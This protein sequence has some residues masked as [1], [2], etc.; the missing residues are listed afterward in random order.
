MAKYLFGEEESG[1]I[2]SVYDLL[3]KPQVQWGVIYCIGCGVRLIPKVKGEEMQ[4]HFAHKV[5]QECSQ[6][7]Y[8]H[9]LGKRLFLEQYRE[10]LAHNTPF[11]IDISYANRCRK[12]DHLNIMPAKDCQLG[13]TVKRFDLTTYYQEIILEQRDGDFIPDLLLR[14]QKNPQEKI[15]IEIAVTSFLSEKKAHSG[16]RVIEIRL[17]SDADI[18]S[19]SARHITADDALLIGFDQAES[20]IVD[21]ECHC[22]FKT[23]FVFYLFPT[24][25]AILKEKS[26]AAIAYDLRSKAIIHHKVLLPFDRNDADLEM[27]LLDSPLDKRDFFIGEL[28]KAFEHGFKVRNCFLCRYHGVNLYDSGV[29]CRA[30]RMECSSNF[31]VE[32]SWF[33][34]L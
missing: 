28:T 3:E 12:Y 9:Q 4:P 11:Y 23:Y 10:A 5:Q 27:G 29:Y 33:R 24:G 7:S 16:N 25:K 19:I 2:I 31:A 34:V 30:K 18:K 15:Y 14:S 6:E 17:D 21:S 32:C 13:S 8:L 26:L 1:A 22:A 20:P